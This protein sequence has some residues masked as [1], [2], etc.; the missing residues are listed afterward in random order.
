LTNTAPSSRLAR[1]HDTDFTLESAASGRTWSRLLCV[2]DPDGP[3]S[4]FGVALDGSFARFSM[5]PS[6]MDFDQVSGASEADASPVAVDFDSPHAVEHF[7]LGPRIGAGG[8]AVVHEAHLPGDLERYAVKLCRPTGSSRADQTFAIEATVMEALKHDHIVPLVAS[9]ETSGGLRWLAMPHILGQTLR[10]ILDRSRGV[11]GRDRESLLRAV[12]LPAFLQLCSAVQYAHSLGVLHCDLKPS[13]VVIE[14]GGH[15]WLLDWGMTKTCAVAA[16]PLGP[17]DLR[18]PSMTPVGGTPGYMA[19]EQ[20]RGRIDR[21]GP[22]SD[23]WSL[24][25]ILYELLSGQRAFRRGDADTMRFFRRMLRSAP[26]RADLRV[27]LPANVVAMAPLCESALSRDPRLR[28]GSARQLA[29]AVQA[30]LD[31]IGWE[32]KG[33]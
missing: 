15:A 28:P 30:V 29:D 22:W 4:V 26:T 7:L 25:S 16:S 1:P 10:Q 21:L 33:V 2:H 11:H 14:P 12:L 6:S 18:S 17:R 9:G 13:N 20:I 8:M 24:G 31:Q 23:V 19:P 3:S 32:I 27:S 5:L